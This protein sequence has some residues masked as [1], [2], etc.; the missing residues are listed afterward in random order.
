MLDHIFMIAHTL[1]VSSACRVPVAGITGLSYSYTC[2][3]MDGNILGKGTI[4]MAQLL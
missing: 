4:G 2:D 1:A 3:V